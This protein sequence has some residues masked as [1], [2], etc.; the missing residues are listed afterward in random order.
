MHTENVFDSK[1]TP[2]ARDINNI[3]FSLNMLF[4]S[5]SS[6]YCIISKKLYWFYEYQYIN[7][8]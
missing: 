7:S 4:M 1:V 6:A 5:L 8:T 3:L 2:S